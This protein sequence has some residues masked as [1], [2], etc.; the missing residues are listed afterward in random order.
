M[1]SGTPFDSSAAKD[2]FNATDNQFMQRNARLG[3]TPRQQDLNRLWAHYRCV[4]YDSR[5][6]DWDGTERSNNLDHE[7]IATAGFIPP[8]FYD[9]SGSTL[10]LKYRRPS[11]PYALAKIIVDRFSG[12]LFSERRH[13]QIRVEGDDATEDYVQALIEQARLWPTMVQARTYGGAM[14]SVACGFSFVEGKPIIEVYDPRWCAPVF[15]DRATKRLK[16]IEIRYQYPITQ[17]DPETGMWLE[18]P[19]WYRRIIN[20]THDVVFHPAPVGDGAEPRWQIEQSSEHGFGF[21]PVVWCQNL[22]VLD[23]IDG[24]CDFQGTT[25]LMNAIDTLL[26]QANR[27]TVSNCVGVET[28][29]ITASGVKTFADFRD[30]DATVVLTHAG[31]WMP[32]LVKAYGQ[33]KLFMLRIGRGPNS[34]IV[35]A[36]E[37]HRWLLADGRIVTTKELS[38]GSKLYKPPHLIRDWAFD[39]ATEEQKTYWAQGFCYGDGSVIRKGGRVYGC[40]LRLCGK[41]TRFLSRFESLGHSVTYTP[42]CN[43]EPTVYVK[44]YNKT[45]P[46]LEDIGFEN[47]MAFVRGYLDADGSR[48]LKHPETSD[49]NP[50]QGIQVTGEDQIAFVRSVFPAVGAYIVNEDDRTDESTNFGERTD[51]TVYFSLV[52]GFAN[53]PVSPY[54]VREIQEDQTEEVWCLEVEEDQSFVLPNGIVTK[55]CDPTVILSTD[56]EFDTVRKG[57]DNAI[58]MPA[59]S[60]ASY[61]EINGSSSKTALELADQFRKYA[62]EVAQ[63][64]IDQDSTKN[65]MRTATEIQRSHAAML[66]KADI[67]REQYGE[68]LVKPLIEMMLKAAQLLDQPRQT[69]DGQLVRQTLVL[70][71]RVVERADG[72]VEYAAQE[73]G[74]G[75]ILALQWPDY[76]EPT[77]VDAKE[78]AQAVST[79][80][81]AGVLDDETAVHYLAPFFRVDNPS[82]MLRRIR[83]VAEE[84][85]GRLDKSLF[86]S[87]K[88]KLGVE[89]DKDAQETE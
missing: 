68:H 39:E 54:I 21:C 30:G 85:T 16:G 40:R 23:D 1:S 59:G 44:G 81:G 35:R 9:A 34:Q 10:P 8:G 32:A 41:K 89:D 15:T 29:F 38:E 46:S 53:S 7:A 14:G 71:P 47:M 48:N 56:A 5:K 45:T 60:N 70:P 65:V 12:L 67:L 6:V 28:P 57:S 63:C 17:Q 62:L 86:S 19:Y 72:V 58:T 64:V 82:E 61:L 77:Y 43:G 18:V 84:Q 51:T 52:L 27:G 66:A 24:D 4:Q 73:L 83:K 88:G 69:E 75:G 76:F 3:M 20:Q 42:S 87:L 31:R 26:S 78:A 74:R 25:D 22:P 50:F 2:I 37:G 33:Q 49:I 80:R 13:P 79:A 36:T 55:N 11:T